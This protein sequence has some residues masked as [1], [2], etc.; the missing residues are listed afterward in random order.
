MN[1]SQLPPPQMRLLQ[2]SNEEG[3]ETLADEMAEFA[4]HGGADQSV[5]DKFA[6]DEAP[7]APPAAPAAMVPAG[8]APGPQEQPKTSLEAKV[9]CCRLGEATPGACGRMH[10]VSPL[11]PPVPAPVPR[12]CMSHWGCSGMSPGAPA[13][14]APISAM[15]RRPGQGVCSG[16]AVLGEE[17]SLARAGGAGA[18]LPRL[19]PALPHAGQR[20]GWRSVLATLTHALRAPLLRACTP[21]GWGGGARPSPRRRAPTPVPAPGGAHPR[22]STATTTTPASQRC[23]G[24]WA[25]R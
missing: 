25:W 12:V 3:I 19:A 16:G 14:A 15:P 22:P 11:S 21:D 1:Y 10:T 24:S 6:G 9:C 23:G 20:W 2:E 8:H 17:S 13:S 7:S 18:G 5:G 4:E